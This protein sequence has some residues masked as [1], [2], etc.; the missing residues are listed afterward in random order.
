MSKITALYKPRPKK[1]VRSGIKS[2]LTPRLPD[3]HTIRCIIKYRKLA[4]EA[5]KSD[6]S[7]LATI[8]QLQGK[9]TP[10]TG[11]RDI[12]E[13]LQKIDADGKKQAR[14]FNRLA[15]QLERFV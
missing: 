15:D 7:S 10:T 4:E 11:E 2:V 9:K 6:P 3:P 1:L 5:G 8:R 12:L 13:I 14:K